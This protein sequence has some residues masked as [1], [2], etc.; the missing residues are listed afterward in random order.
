MTLEKWLLVVVLLISGGA[1]VGIIKTKTRGWGRFSTS[2]LLLTL[3]LFT[4]TIALVSG[5]MQLPE[6][7]NLLF[8]VAGFGGGLLTGKD[9]R[10]PGVTPQND[11]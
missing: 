5:R 3:V 2:V 1:I 8:A 4:T 9:E 11:R 6:V 7:A 10:D